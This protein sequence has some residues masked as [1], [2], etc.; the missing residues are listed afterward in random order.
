MLPLELLV[1]SNGEMVLCWEP[2]HCVHRE[3]YILQTQRSLML[4]FFLCVFCAFV[5]QLLEKAMLL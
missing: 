2:Q 5:P 4:C 3:K 1:L